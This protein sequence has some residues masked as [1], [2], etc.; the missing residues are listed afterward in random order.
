MQDQDPERSTVQKNRNPKGEM[1][2]DRL[3]IHGRV[4][5]DLTTNEFS[6]GDKW[7][8][9]VSKFV[10]KLRRH[11]NSRERET[12]EAIHWKFVSPRLRF[13]FRSDGGSKFNDR[14]HQLQLERKQQ[15][16]M[17]HCQIL[18]T[19]RSTEDAKVVKPDIQCF[20]HHW[21]HGI[22]KKKKNKS[23]VVIS[24]NPHQFTIK[25]DGSTFK[26]LFI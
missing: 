16:Q 19:G 23:I 25:Q 21:A 20:S 18:A 5:E 9:Q 26:T 4:W 13:K 1:S 24:Q 10:S 8:I 2:D 22:L 14:D 11:E 15:N 7:E 12:D 17:T 6:D 3:P